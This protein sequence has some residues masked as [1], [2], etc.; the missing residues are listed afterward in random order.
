MKIQTCW[1]WLCSV[2]K[3]KSSD[4]QYDEGNAHS[5]LQSQTT[6]FCIFCISLLLKWDKLFLLPILPTW[7]RAGTD[8]LL[9]SCCP[10]DE[11]MGGLVGSLVPM[12]VMSRSDIRLPPGWS[13][14]CL[15]V[16]LEKRWPFWDYDKT[17]RTIST[18]KKRTSRNETVASNIKLISF[19]CFG[20]IHAWTG[21]HCLTTIRY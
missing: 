3:S 12:R 17:S 11:G 1:W 8:L 19:I 10:E 4:K 21:E 2:L 5:K 6:S 16:F 9:G 7:C 13:E 20:L 14:S 18:P 15:W